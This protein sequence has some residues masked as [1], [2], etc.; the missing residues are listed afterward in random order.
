MDAGGAGRPRRYDRSWRRQNL[1]ARD[2]AR[3]H[4][5]APGDT[6]RELRGC[7][8]VTTSTRRSPTWAPVSCSIPPIREVSRATKLVYL[9]AAM[10]RAFSAWRDSGGWTPVT[11]RYFPAAAPGEPDPLDWG[12]E[13]YVQAVLGEAFGLRFEED[14]APFTGPSG[15][16]IWQLAVP[17]SGPFKARCCARGTP[18]GCL[19]REFVDYLDGHRQDGLVDVPRPICSLSGFVA[20]ERIG[21]SCIPL[22]R[23]GLSIRRTASWGGSKQ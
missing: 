10:K 15:G 6:Y 18:P 23:L 7:Q 5:S 1:V 9:S 14:D 21:Q 11:R 19:R 8:A 16:K 22:I 4:H 13:H 3:G 12:R 17:A 2:R 20:A